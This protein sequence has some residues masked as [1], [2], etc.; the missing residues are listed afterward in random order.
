MIGSGTELRSTGS[1][2]VC[3]LSGIKLSQDCKILFIKSL[4]DSGI[5]IEIGT[6]VGSIKGLGKL[7]DKS[8]VISS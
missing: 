7:S 8:Y 5:S 6:T 3:S 1:E 4:S 2:R